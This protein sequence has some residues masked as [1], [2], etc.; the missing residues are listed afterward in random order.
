M[1]AA[2]SADVGA[3]LARV[4]FA[5]D[6]QWAG[7]GDDGGWGI[8]ALDA[9]QECAVE[10]LRVGLRPGLSVTKLS[11]EFKGS[12]RPDKALNRTTPFT[13]LP[14]TI[15]KDDWIYVGHGRWQFA[16]HITL[17]EAR[18][19]VKVVAMLAQCR[20]ARRRKVLLLEDNMPVACSFAKGRSQAPALD[21]LLRK[22]VAFATAGQTQLLLPWVE[23]ALQPADEVS[24]LQ[25]TSAGVA[26]G[27]APV[28]KDQG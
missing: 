20:A 24:R 23:T 28:G 21:F 2:M 15:F 8:V 7:E 19:A 16:D 22:R 14:H 27:P 10:C 3:P 5:S 6:A 13:R 11:G 25:G 9:G 26:P 12:L 1:F 18:V 4:I 17:G